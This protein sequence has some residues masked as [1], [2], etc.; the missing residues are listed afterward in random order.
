MTHS[1]VTFCE[2]LPVAQR[3]SFHG[4]DRDRKKDP[5]G[6]PASRLTASSF[7]NL[8]DYLCFYPHPPLPHSPPPPSPHFSESGA[9]MSQ[10]QP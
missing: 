4:R 6:H 10:W 5:S 8:S 3:N 7:S 2:E 1:A 9:L